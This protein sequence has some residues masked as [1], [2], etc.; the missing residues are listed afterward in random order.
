L[1]TKSDGMY[2]FESTNYLASLSFR[3]VK[4]QLLQHNGIVSQAP[5]MGRY[6]PPEFP[7]QTYDPRNNTQAALDAIDSLPSIPLPIRKLTPA[8]RL[9]E[10]SKA[11]SKFLIVSDPLGIID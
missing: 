3:T 6:I 2:F 4:F 7:P 11:L 5:S 9:Y 1:L 10:T 8:G